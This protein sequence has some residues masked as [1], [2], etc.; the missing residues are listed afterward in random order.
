MAPRTRPAGLNAQ[1]ELAVTRGIDFLFARQQPH[2][3]FA[4][5]GAT[6]E[7]LT[8]DC[9]LDSSPFAT[10]LILYSLGF[11]TDSRVAGI[12]EQ[13]L[14]F[15]LAEMEG[16]GLWR[17]WSRTNPLHNFLPPDLDDTCCI[18]FLLEKYGR[19]FPSNRALIL[20]NRNEVGVFYTWL[21][22]R[23]SLSQK[24]MRAIR[25]VSKREVEVVLSLS[26]TLDNVDCAVNANVLLYLGES[27]TTQSAIEYWVEMVSNAQVSSLYY[28][29]PLAIDYM[30]SRAYANGIAAFVKLKPT[31]TAY[32]YATQARNGSW[33]NPL[34]TALAACTLLNFEEQTNALTRAVRY[35]LKTQKTDGS[36]Q[37]H[38]LYLGPAPYYGSEELTAALCVE[39]L[40]RSI[41]LL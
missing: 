28:L 16:A 36:W 32:V 13:G 14:D 15:L 22:A 8:T 30:L 38:A 34:L 33:K 39:A 26:G 23:E 37:R 7:T 29:H 40:S 9:E 17:Y 10:A 11:C 12:V 35:L 19:P 41:L 1:V 25:R 2:G 6:D 27:E 31:I 4:L 3:E 18:S 21:A 24:F 5:Y 20:A